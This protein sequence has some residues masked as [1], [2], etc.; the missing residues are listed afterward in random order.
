MK[1]TDQTDSRKTRQARQRADRP[2][3]EQKNQTERSDK[4][5]TQIRPDGSDPTDQTDNIPHR[6]DQIGNLTDRSG[7]RQIDRLV[8]KPD[9]ISRPDIRTRY[10]TCIDQQTDQTNRP[11]R[12]TR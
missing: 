9:K 12:Q 8:D 2:D 6:S 7:Y 4:Q 11:E 5:I 3:R 1:Q 10:T